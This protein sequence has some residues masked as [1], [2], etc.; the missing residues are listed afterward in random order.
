MFSIIVCSID[1]QK[2][3][4]LKRNIEDTASMPFEVLIFD[5]RNVGLG[6][7]AVYNK[8]AEQA[9]YDNL[10]FIHEDII[11]HGKGWD[12]ILAEKFTEPDC[13]VIGFAGGTAKY[14]LPY[15]W[16][17]IMK[18]VRRN[19]IQDYSPTRRK[20]AKSRTSEHYTPVVTLDGMFLGVRKD[21]WSSVRFDEQ[22]FSAFHSYDTD[23]TTSV[24]V[25][26]YK[27]YVCNRFMIEHMSAGSFSSAWYESELIYLNKW[28]NHLPL[29]VPTISC[30]QIEKNLCATEA[31]SLRIKLKAKVLSRSQALEELKKFYKK[32]PLS[33]RILKLLPKYFKL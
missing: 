14:P 3:E 1:P 23:F 11:F 24:F 25:A 15:G 19:Y 32:Y 22:T 7:C 13:G 30:K 29:S 27:N 28:S 4:N 33:L 6:L 21:V 31:H 16:H 17:G 5:N 18:F 2:A 26:G 8:M 20:I 10:L 9:Q 12:A